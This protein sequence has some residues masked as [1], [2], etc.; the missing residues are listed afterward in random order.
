MAIFR[1]FD[2]VD[3]QSLSHAR[4]SNAGKRILVVSGACTTAILGIGSGYAIFIVRDPF[5]ELACISVT[6][7]TMVSVV[8]RNYGSRMAVDLQ[9]FF[10]LPADDRL[11]PDGAGFLS[12]LFSRSSSFLSG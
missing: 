8:G 4:K 11:Q 10:L 5:A 2:R 9:T 7:A 3:K 12:R 1:M 6:M